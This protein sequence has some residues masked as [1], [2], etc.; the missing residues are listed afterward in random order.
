MRLSGHVPFG[1]ERQNCTIDSHARRETS[2]ACDN[3]RHG[4]ARRFGGCC[5]LPR[6]RVFVRSVAAV[7]VFKV[8]EEAMRFNLSSLVTSCVLVTVSGCGQEPQ[9]SPEHFGAIHQSLDASPLTAEYYKSKTLTGEVVLTQ[10]DAINM[11]WMDGAPLAGFPADDFSVRWTGKVTPPSTG[12]YTFYIYAYDGARVWVND[13]LIID[14]WAWDEGEE[15]SA[16]IALVGGQAYN[17]KVEYFEGGGAARAHLSWSG[18][19]VAKSYVPPEALSAPVTQTCSTPEPLPPPTKTS[20]IYRNDF[21]GEDPSCWAARPSAGCNGAKVYERSRYGST[22]IV[23]IATN[24]QRRSG[25]KALRM[26]FSRDEDEGGGVI[27]PNATHVF[28]RH[29]D[30]YA[31]DFDFAGGMKIARFSGHDSAL[32]LNQYDIILVSRAQAINGNYCGRNDMGTMY[33]QRNGGSTFGGLFPAVSFPRGQWVAVETEIKLNTPGAADGEVRVYVDGQRKIEATNLNYV[34]DA[35]DN[36]PINSLLMG[37]WF[38]NGG[39]NLPD[40]I[41]PY[42]VSKRYI[43][44]VIVSSTYVG[45][46]PT[47]T[48][49]TS[50]TDQIVRFT[51]PVAGTTQVEYGATASYGSQT[52]VNSSQVTAHEQS[53]TGLVPGKAYHYRV[54][55][56]WSNGYQYVSPD[57]TFVAK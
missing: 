36:L 20:E 14:D 26:T 2:A 28:Y 18:P 4:G 15:A 29:Y 21:E 47:V 41:H 17:L 37:G 22:G 49:G 52:P 53:L 31:S 54:K 48:R 35:N 12:N 44:D 10:D 51:T 3:V 13:Q 5:V 8:K 1:L 23:G 55:S 24:E 6:I 25:Q 27:N 34:R 50:C 9:P 32:G 33:L 7:G 16:P 46:E 11:N 42:A 39:N 40:C 30:Y 45:P 56:S 19:G 57:Y 43:D 38:S